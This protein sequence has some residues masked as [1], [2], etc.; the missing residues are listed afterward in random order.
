M[1]RYFKHQG[2]YLLFLWSIFVLPLWLFLQ[3]SPYRAPKLSYVFM[4]GLF[5]SQYGFYR[6]KDYRS[7]IKSK[8]TSILKEEQGRIPSGKE[9]ILRSNQVV[10]F[11]GVSIVVCSIAILIL[12]FYY[13]DF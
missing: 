10:Q 3:F 12:M 4:G 1:I 13:N 11:R 9:V 8:V 5:V 6:E 2:T 7:K